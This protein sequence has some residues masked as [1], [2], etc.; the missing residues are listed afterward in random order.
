[1]GP[2]ACGLPLALLPPAL[3]GAGGEGQSVGHGVQPAAQRPG[4]VQR[5]G[6]ADQDEEGGLK[7]VLGGVAVVQHAAA[8]PEVQ[9]AVAAPQHFDRR[10]VAVGQELLQELA[11]GQGR[12]RD[13]A[14]QMAEVIQERVRMRR[15]HARVL[16]GFIP[17]L[18]SYTWQRP[19]VARFFSEE[20]L[21]CERAGPVTPARRASETSPAAAPRT[22]AAAVP[23]CSSRSARTTPPA[24]AAA[25][26]RPAGSGC[27]RRPAAPRPRRRGR[28][29][30]ASGCPPPGAA[31]CPPSRPPPS[32]PPAGPTRC[33]TSRPPRRRRRRRAATSR[34]AASSA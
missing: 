9:R 16:R 6:L 24:P 33:R 23:A 3:V 7:D 21:F 22:P 4:A 34:P 1:G 5:R 25:C 26:P 8:A 20:T 27:R 31:P 11:V 32:A 19:R 12:R 10:L 18:P 13:A 30:P 2:K 15:G 28:T 29:A 17:V 14:D